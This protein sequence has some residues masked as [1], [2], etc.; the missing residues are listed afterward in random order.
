VDRPF[1]ALLKASRETR[2]LTQQALADQIG[3]S[4]ATVRKYEQEL[5]WPGPDV[6]PSLART[7][8]LSVEQLSAAIAAS[9]ASRIRPPAEPRVPVS[10]AAGSVPEPTSRLVARLVIAI[11][12]VIGLFIGMQT[13]TAWWMRHDAEPGDRLLVVA[14]T[15]QSIAVLPTYNTTAGVVPRDAP[16]Q[17]ELTVRNID[18]HRVMVRELGVAVRGPDG[19][20]LTPPT[21]HSVLFDPG[22]EIRYRAELR[23]T[24]PGTYRLEP[25]AMDVYGAWV[26]LKQ[27]D[28]LITVQLTAE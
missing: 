4:L 2:D 1:G 25:R 3:V 6:I 18:P 16:L 17:I 21:L 10:V 19:T 27:D 22:A 9:R 28:K 11:A 24:K 5:R 20:L 15:P 7:L 13:W 8:G 23:L 14:L 26:D 12:L